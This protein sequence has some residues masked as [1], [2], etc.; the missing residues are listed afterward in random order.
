MSIQVKEAEKN[1][2]EFE[3]EISAADFDEA[4]QKAYKKNLKNFNIP[5]FRKGK[6]PFKIVEQYYGKGI[7]YDDAINF[8]FPAV[9][10]AA[11]KET[12]LEPVDRPEV[13]IKELED[14]KPVV[15]TVR[16]TVKPS[17]KLGD[18]KGIEVEKAEYNVSDAD[19]DKELE[20]K[21]EQNA[22]VIDIDD[23]AV[24]NG[25]IADINY[26]GFLDGV[27]FEGGKG[28]GHKLTIG[29]GQ[30]I[31]GFEEQLIGKNIGEEFDI[32]VTFPEEY[33]AEELKGKPAVFKVKIN[34]IS[35]RELPELDD[36]FAKDI[37]E[38]D[39]LDELKAEIKE[40]LE[41]KAKDTADA[42]NRNNVIDKILEN[43]E[44]EIPAV[45]VEAQIDNIMRDF[46]MRLSY[47]GMKLEQYLQY[48][49]SDLAKF[50]E[51]FK[52]QAE[53]Q[54]KT[55]LMLEEVAKLEKVEAT[56]EEIDTEL[57]KMA[58]QYKMEMDKIRELIQGEYLDSLKNDIAINK[59]VDM[60]VESA[61]LK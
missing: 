27:P 23:R 4:I 13:D 54:V 51:Q 22:R 20:I 61:N 35:K 7:L 33:H 26:E 40:D 53:K 17:V 1:V 36:E 56:Q 38:K 31:P 49:G 41:K 28:E 11:I 10:D 25:D 6:V 21:R 59:T 12:G 48:T 46:E 45:M 42:Q 19:V 55:S 29:S 8:A 37:S 32:N 58:E 57:T 50:R 44:V 24:E 30:F 15:L 3:L 18:Y 16:V 2:R 9:Y 39:T 60:L 52:E 5:G 14:G 47:S 43:V 34:G